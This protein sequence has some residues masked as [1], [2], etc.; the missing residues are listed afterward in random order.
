[1]AKASPPP[2][3]KNASETPVSALSFEAALRELEAIVQA[4]EAGNA[5]LEESLAAYERGMALLKRGQATLAAAETKIRL[6]DNGV[7]REFDATDQ[8]GPED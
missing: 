7:L 5:P 2:S 1:M 6:L 4:M 8:G 3:E